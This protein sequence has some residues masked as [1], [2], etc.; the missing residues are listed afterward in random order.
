MLSVTGWLAD[1]FRLA[2]GLLYWNTRKSWFR[3]RRGRARCPC[4]SPSDSGRAFETQCDAVVHWTSPERFR[5]LCPLLVKTPQGWRC[6]V[7][8]PDVRPFWGRA[9]GYYGG[10]LAAVYLAGVIT[11][12]IFLRTV[13]YPVSVFHVAWPPSWHRVGQARGWFFMEKARQSFAANR[14]SEAILYLSNAYEFDPANYAAGLTLAKT[15]QAGQPLVSNRLYDRLLHEH[16]AQ[17]DATAQEWFRALLAR[18]DFETISSLAGNEVL[19][20]GPHASVWM[21]AL[22]FAARQTHR[23]TAL[24][25]LRDS[26][27]PAATVWQPLLDAELFSLAGRNAD[28]RL[29]LDRTDWKRLPPYGIY[30]QVNRLT[31]LGDV[32]A[33]LDSLD[34]N[35]AGLDVET[36]VTLELTAYG[37]QGALRPLHQ[38]ANRLLGPKLNL[39]VITLLAAQLIRYP[40]PVLLEQVYARFR[41]EPIAFTTES[42]GAYFSLLCAAAVNGDWPKFDVL[43][44]S[45]TQHAGSSQA[46]LTAVE[47]FFRG[48][49]G[50]TRVTSYL[51]ALPLPLEVNYALIERYPGTPV[52]S[53]P[54]LSSPAKVGS[55]NAPPEALADRLFVCS[56]PRLTTN[57]P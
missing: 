11:V 27:S 43:R 12:F 15:L 48:R 55:S 50:A 45:I 38:L 40:D 24:R 10:A 7:N 1:F 14:T 18:G 4:Q 30:Y 19:A 23:D 13:G 29:L 47:A 5:R 17:H 37:R 54:T 3:L 21:R 57:P 39:P 56:T 9:F 41:A 20:G 42:A 35:G 6:S 28:A 51:P 2:S 31:E 44:A 53:V 46:V 16:P 36:R 8:T 49:T 34:R 25:A 22:V 33:A 26:P 52:R 32:Y